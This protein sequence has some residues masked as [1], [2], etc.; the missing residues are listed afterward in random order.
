MW[1]E[2]T[3][4]SE[5]GVFVSLWK[6]ASLSVNTQFPKLPVDF[7]LQPLTPYHI[8]LFV[9]SKHQFA[10]PLLEN[11]QGLSCIAAVCYLCKN[12]HCLKWVQLGFLYLCVAPMY[13]LH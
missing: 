1:K 2:L 8:L 4:S 9:F 5:G 11:L 7:C 6:S 12:L 13:W 3:G 10:H